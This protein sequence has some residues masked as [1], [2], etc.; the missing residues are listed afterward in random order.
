MRGD[1]PFL[2]WAVA[3]RALPGEKRSGDVATVLTSASR[4]VLAVID[5]LGHGDE[6]ADAAELAAQAIEQNRAEPLEA[7]LLLAH[8]ELATSRGVAATVAIIDGESGRMDWV[9]V[10]NVDGLVVRA[11]DEVK[12][13]TLG[14]FLCRGVLGYRLP[15][16]HISA[17]VHLEDGDSIVIATDGVR[18]DLTGAVSQDIPVGRSADTILA[19]C[20]IADD[21]ALVF[22]ARYRSPQ[23]LTA[24][25]EEHE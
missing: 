9:G 16:L 23:V 11:D 2:E 5:G 22:V 21:D 18:G 15:P 10:G 6:A 19:Q 17:P 3:G 24:A 13:R 1:A 25:G 14:V 8:E 12:P 7:L 4:C 20:A